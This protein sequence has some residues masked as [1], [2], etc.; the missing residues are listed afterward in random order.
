M[1]FRKHVVQHRKWIKVLK[2]SVY[3]ESVEWKRMEGLKNQKDLQGKKKRNARL[4]NVFDCLK[5]N[6]DEHFT[7]VLE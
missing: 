3:Q 5:I 7:S 4:N 1:R 6:I 2:S